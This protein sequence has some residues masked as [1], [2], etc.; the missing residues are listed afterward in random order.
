MITIEALA[1]QEQEL[2]R[3]FAAGDP[4]LARALYQPDVVYVSP[5]VRLF[6]WPAEIAGIERTLEFIRLTI[7][8]C[9]AIEYRAVELAI[10]PDAT[11]AFVRVDFDWT[12]AGRRL[13]SRYVVR[14]RYRDGRIARQEL[15]YDPSAAPETLARAR[16]PTG[17]G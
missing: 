12:H 3:A 5:T 10:V 17:I 13:R 1:A 16:R 11:A 7:R 6:D 4:G 2:G 14:Y 9:A 15:Y 8:R